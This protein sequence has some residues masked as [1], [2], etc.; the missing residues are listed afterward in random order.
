MLTRGSLLSPSSWFEKVGTLFWHDAPQNQA[1]VKH[2]L[3]TC[4]WCVVST[5]VLV[6]MMEFSF[7]LGLWVRL[8]SLP[9]TFFDAKA[10]DKT[11]IGSYKEDAQPWAARPRS[12]GCCRG[13]AD[14]PPLPGLPPTHQL[15]VSSREICGK[16]NRIKWMK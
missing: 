13:W 8:C 7:P 6:K 14:V 11:Q 3:I 15:L 5:A 4:M 9:V 12:R 10:L 16:P 2:N 1:L